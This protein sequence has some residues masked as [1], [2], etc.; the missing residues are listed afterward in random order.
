M[1]KFIAITFTIAFF[2]TAF[3]HNPL[4]ATKW[5]YSDEKNNVVFTID[6]S[7]AGAGSLTSMED[8]CTFTYS[9]N[10]TQLFIKVDEC[11]RASASGIIPCC[12]Q[13]TIN[14]KNGPDGTLILV[15]REM[16]YQLQP[17]K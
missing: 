1:K 6:F 9:A 10:H 8:N 17:V 11:S 5:S 12:E 3:A 4:Q 7:S 16:E 14:M 13:Q 2:I 15:I